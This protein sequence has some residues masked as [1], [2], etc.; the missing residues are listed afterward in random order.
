MQRRR[1]QDEECLPRPATHRSRREDRCARTPSVGLASLLGCRSIVNLARS[2]SKPSMAAS[3]VSSTA[4][5]NAVPGWPVNA[6]KAIP[7][8]LS[9]TLCRNKALAAYS[10][11]R[12]A[13]GLFGRLALPGWLLSDAQRCWAAGTASKG[14]PPATSSTDSSTHVGSSLHA[15]P[16][17]VHCCSIC[18][19]VTCS[20]DLAYKHITARVDETVWQHHVGRGG[21]TA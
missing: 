10:M 4:K 18:P 20:S 8:S 1:L 7:T 19:G 3:Q 11:Q 9:T 5:T 12:G 14:P 13:W 15:L 2:R 16:L 6:C 17:H 21:Q